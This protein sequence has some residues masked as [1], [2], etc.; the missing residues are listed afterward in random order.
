MFIIGAAFLGLIVMLLWNALIPVLFHGPELSYLQAVG[1][2]VLCRLLVGIRGGRRGWRPWKRWSRHHNWGSGPKQEWKYNV[3]FGGPKCR[4]EWSSKFA[5]MSP[6]ERQ[7]LKDEW[8]ADKNK[9]KSEFKK[10]FDSS[11]PPPAPNPG[12]EIH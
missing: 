3:N 11:A 6:E 8:R 10:H 4:D 12:E 1:L 9:W 2:L 5:G 7:R